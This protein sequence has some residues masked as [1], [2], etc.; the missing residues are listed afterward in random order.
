MK[1]CIAMGSLCLLVL[2]SG[3]GPGTSSTRKKVLE[4]LSQVLQ[5][6][7]N[8]LGGV[9]SPEQAEVARP[10]LE[11]NWEIYQELVTRLDSLSDVFVTAAETGPIRMQEN[12]VNINKHFLRANWDALYGRRPYGPELLEPFVAFRQAIS[13]DA[14]SPTGQPVNTPAAGR[15]ATFTDADGESAR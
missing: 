10:Q 8:L 5:E 3:C 11:R 14:G 1:K 12:V 13:P 15:G 7:A 2:A 6:T 9:N 4:D